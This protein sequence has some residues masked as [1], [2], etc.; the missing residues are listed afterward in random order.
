MH[1]AAT[2][3]LLQ[4]EYEA[5]YVVARLPLQPVHL[6]GVYLHPAYCVATALLRDAQLLQRTNEGPLH[7]H[8]CVY[9]GLR[10]EEAAD[11]LASVPPVEGG[12]HAL[13]F[14]LLRSTM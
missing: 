12:D 8:V 5:E 11:L 6:L 7:L 1:K 2:A 9:Y 3:L 14:S 13:P 4:K 10:G